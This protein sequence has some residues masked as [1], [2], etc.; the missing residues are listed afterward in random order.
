M[1]VA[2]QKTIISVLIEEHSDNKNYIHIE[3]IGCLETD[4]WSPFEKVYNTEHLVYQ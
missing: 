4:W 2:V 1:V 3:E